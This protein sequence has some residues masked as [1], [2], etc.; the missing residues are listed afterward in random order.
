MNGIKFAS[1]QDEL[2]Q[3]QYKDDDG[4]QIEGYGSVFNVIDE[5]GDIVVQ[6]AYANVIEQF[7]LTGF[8]G[9]SHKWGFGDSIGYPLLAYEDEY[10]LYIVRQFYKTPDAQ[11]VRQK[12]SERLAAK[13]AVGLSVGFTAEKILKIYRAN[14]AAELPKYIRPELLESQ[15]L[16]AQSFPMIRVI[17]EVKYLFEDSIVCSPMNRMAL[18]SKVKS[19]P[20][21]AELEEEWSEE[22][23]AQ[24]VTE[25]SHEVESE[26]KSEVGAVVDSEPTTI[27][28]TP[29]TTVKTN[30]VEEPIAGVPTVGTPTVGTPTV[31]IPT[32]GQETA[33]QSVGK[34]APSTK[35][36]AIAPLTVQPEF[37]G[38]LFGD[39]IGES[40]TFNSITRLTEIM[41]WSLI[42]EVVFAKSS[43]KAEKLEMLGQ[44]I[45]EYA[46]H[47][48]NISAALLTEDGDTKSLSEEAQQERKQIEAGIANPFFTKARDFLKAGSPLAGLTFQEHSQ[49]TLAVSKEYSNR[50]ADIVMTRL[51][52]G[53]KISTN[54]LN[55]MRAW[56][57]S[58]VEMTSDL[59]DL[60]EEVDPTEKGN[61]PQGNTPKEDVPTKDIPTKD[62]STE[63][64]PAMGSETEKEEHPSPDTGTASETLAADS[65]ETGSPEAT[66]AETAS[67]QVKQEVTQQETVQE[68][69]QQTAEQE[70]IAKQQA[71]EQLR[72]KAL[73]QR[74]LI[75]RDALRR[76]HEVVSV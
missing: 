12:V 52:E 55:R 34:D 69:V 35:D 40:L 39:Y 65:P 60:I 37:K 13:K 23:M 72:I 47:V 66:L 74:A 63:T 10:G 51:K 67:E 36:T 49:L 19:H 59:G 61:T 64:S 24:A 6:G 8:T 1:F 29:P 56:Y 14:Y 16:K 58:L 57:D 11:N 54:T 25:S 21:F 75:A 73:Q 38:G 62:A 46:Q 42:Y 30:P 41:I 27:T 15:L 53:R 45:A 70:E 20:Y 28:T 17:Q 71:L 22:E 48:M 3:L 4:G 2:F 43:S 5:G 50:L 33:G 9:D 44:I 26:A 32:V 18:A 76:E 31:G 68:T 7:L